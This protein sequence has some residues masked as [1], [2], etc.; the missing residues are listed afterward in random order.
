[1]KVGV[2]TSAESASPRPNSRPPD[3]A[4]QRGPNL[5]CM[6]PANTIVIAKAAVETANGCAAS[7]FVQCH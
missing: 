6:R 7:I 4:T 2:R 1:M 3:T 5:S